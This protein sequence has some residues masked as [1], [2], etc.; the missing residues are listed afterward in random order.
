ML[1]N[2]LAAS[3]NAVMNPLA[4]VAAVA[5]AMSVFVI[6]VPPSPPVTLAF[7]CDAKPIVCNTCLSLVKANALPISVE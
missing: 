3:N 1:S 6:V 2:A 4:E 7:A 5:F